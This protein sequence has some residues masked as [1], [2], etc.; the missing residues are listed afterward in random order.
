M[1]KIILIA[2]GCSLIGLIL[3]AIAFIGIRGN[4]AELSTRN[5]ESEKKEYTCSSEIQNIVADV[6][7]DNIE[8]LTG[9][10]DHVTLTY[11][12]RT[13]Y[14]EYEITESGDTLRIKYKDLNGPI[15]F[16]VNIGYVPDEP[17]TIIVP[18][19]FAGKLDLKSTS[20]GILTESMSVSSLDLNCTSGGISVQDT[21]S[22]GKINLTTTSGSIHIENTE[23]AGI[24]A[25]NTSGGISINDTDVQGDVTLNCNSG[26]VNLGTVTAEGDIKISTTSGTRTLTDV[27]ADNITTNATSG[28]LKA[29]RVSANDT[30]SSSATSGTTRFEELYVGNNIK[31]NANSG[32]VSGSI[33]GSEDDFSIIANT[34][35]GSCNLSNSRDGEKSLDISTTSGSV[36]I[37][38]TE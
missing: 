21:A 13:D 20:G 26:S 19:S 8:V 3:M 9:D 36:N 24:T 23:S 18:E 32:S 14:S 5:V 2:G 33:I 29:V 25:S 35:S 38:F 31:I 7:S 17:V 34:T 28:S 10:V 11:Y 6:T 12:N 16:V 27:I 37:T 4:I 15:H 30:L 1:K 22:E